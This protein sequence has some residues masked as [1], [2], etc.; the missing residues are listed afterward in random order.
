M[1]M[2]NTTH[3]AGSDPHPDCWLDLTDALERSCNVYFETLGHQLKLEGLAWWFDKFGLGRPTGVGIA[4]FSGRLPTSYQGP[5]RAHS[6]WLASIGQGPV[7][8]TAIQMANVAA[9][10]GRNGVWV[11]PTLVASQEGGAF[12]QARVDLGLSPAALRKTREGL[13]RVIN[14]RGGTAYN[15]GVRRDDLLV[16][17][18]TGSAQ[19]SPTFVTVRDALGNP[20]LDENGRPV[21]RPL[22]P[23]NN[24]RPNPEAPWYRDTGKTKTELTHAWFIGYAPAENPTLAWAVMVEYGGSG[25][26]PAAAIGKAILDAAIEHGYLHRGAPVAMGN[27]ELM[28]DE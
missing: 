24:M 21:R 19:A 2:F 26:G 13:V 5:N 28:Y 8:T 4:E 20:V 27:R 14:K 23:S 25:G 22:Q 17:G 3:A 9:T 6:A 1:S 11:Q 15:S 10:L 18:K 16:A 12:R 7:S